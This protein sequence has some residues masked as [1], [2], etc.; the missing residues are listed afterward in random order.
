MISPNR[1]K[2]SPKRAI[3]MGCWLT[4]SRFLASTFPIC[5]RHWPTVALMVGD[6]AE[7]MHWYTDGGYRRRFHMGLDGATMSRP[8]L[9][10]LVRQRVLALAN[11]S[12]LDN[13]AVKQ[14]LTTP[15]QKHVT[16]VIIERRAAAHQSRRLLADLVVDCSGRGSRAPQW[17]KAL[18][19][20]P[21]PQS[22]V[23]MDVG[24]ASRLYRRAPDDPRGQQWTM[25]T[26]HAPHET[27][28]GAV[29]AIENDRWIVSL[30]GWVAPQPIYSWSVQ[31]KSTS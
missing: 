7:M 11:V 5:R 9:E 20:E 2:G 16:G 27:R 24:Y 15:D 29:F 30:G 26:P 6:M 31:D 4:A 28:F 14:L 22:E 21:P 8:F 1:V 10:H 18:G 19:Y 3:F 17:L 25:V 23:K 12:L 13:C